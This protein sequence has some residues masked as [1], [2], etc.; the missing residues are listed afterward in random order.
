MTLTVLL[1]QHRAAFEYDMQTRVGWGADGLLRGD[2]GWNL[3][4][5]FA[6]GFMRD[7]YSHCHASVMGW[8]YVPNPAD[9]LYANWVDATAQMHHQRGKVPPK[10]V[11]RPWERKQRERPIAFLDAERKKRRTALKERL[12]LNM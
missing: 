12:G 2:R 7:L 1:F 5:A 9:V 10:P 8:A 6:T 4:A 11:R 3:V